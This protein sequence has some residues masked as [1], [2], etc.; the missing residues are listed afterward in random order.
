MNYC[1][2]QGWLEFGPLPPAAQAELTEPAT[3]A[4]KP[5]PKPRAAAKSTQVPLESA[6]AAV[7]RPPCAEAKPSSPVTTVATTSVSKKPATKPAAKKPSAKRCASKRPATASSGSEPA[8]RKRAA[9][10]KTKP[11]TAQ[12]SAAAAVPDRTGAVPDLTDI[13]RT[14]VTTTSAEDATGGGTTAGRSLLDAF[15]S[16]DFLDA[17]R[18]DRL[19]GPLESDDLNSDPESVEEDTEVSVEEVDEEPVTFE[20][21]AVDAAPLYDGPSGPTKAVLAYAEN[22]LA[23]FYFFLPKDLWRRI[24]A[25]TNK[26][27]LDSVD[28]VAQGMRQ[29]ALDKRLTTPST[30]VLSVE[31]D[32]VFHA[33]SRREP[34][35]AV[36]RVPCPQLVKDY[37]EAMGGVDVHDQLRLQ[38]YSIQRSIRMRKYYKTLF[39]S[40]V[41]IAMVNAF[42]VHKLAL[43]KLQKPVPTHAVFMR[44][45]HADPLVQTSE[46]FAGNN[47][48]EE[49]VTQPLP[50]APHTLQKLE[51]KNKAKAKN[52]QWL[53]KV[54]SAFAG[55]GVRSFETSY[56]YATCTRSKRGRVSL[57]NK[58]RRLD[59]GSSLTCDQI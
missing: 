52:R 29:R 38:R 34:G 55:L 47:D 35:G 15:D 10:G 11:T 27:R 30:T 37:H 24:A 2:R 36:S 1:R 56:F 46:N 7:P 5:A 40:L 26:Y 59:H 23:I 42:I 41:D 12:D 58:A 53:C 20:L 21:G 33:A 19:F 32:G 3:A 57:C 45:L 17:L 28:E 16:D 31:D 49:L 25:E 43:R 50:R 39:S 13:A 18:E 8:R 44:R 51:E 4:S 22:P 9:V 6:A 48:L 54:C 14:R